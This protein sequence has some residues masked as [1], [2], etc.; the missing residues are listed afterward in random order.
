M[1][2]RTLQVNDIAQRLTQPEQQMLANASGHKSALQTCLADA[3]AM[4]NSALAA[5]GNQVGPS[6]TTVDSLR[7][8][9]MAYA[10]WQWISSFPTLKTFATEA[11]RDAYKDA[12]A[13]LNKVANR[14]WGAVESPTGYATTGNWGSSPRI[15]G[16]MAGAPPP[17]AQWG[18]FGQNG[19]SQIDANPNAQ[20]LVPLDVVPDAPKNL[21]ATATLATGILIDWVAPLNADYF[22]LYRGS[23]SGSEVGG[24]VFATTKSTSFTDV[25]VTQGT[26]Y[27]YV[28][29]AVN[30][31]GKSAQSN[32]ASAVAGQPVTSVST[33]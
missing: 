17:L 9:V 4:F 15:L 33:N 7:P 30:E 20:S 28:C 8:H 6:G 14:L 1:G 29:V 12:Q 3:I 22:L 32:E 11:R 31:I 21:Q 23:A 13:A 19:L 10:V 27:Y 18:P 26:T 2:W 25:L 16:R 5:V 24:G